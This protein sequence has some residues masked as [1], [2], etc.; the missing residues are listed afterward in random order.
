MSYQ[1][2]IKPELLILVPVIYILGKAMKQSMIPDSHIPT[3]LGV[4]SIALCTLWVAS[5]TLIRTPQEIATAIF[6]SFTQGVLIAGAS[7]YCNQLKRQRE[8]G[9]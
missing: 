1:D 5:T 2:F 9:D 7:V 4:I 3:Y 8:K 6:V